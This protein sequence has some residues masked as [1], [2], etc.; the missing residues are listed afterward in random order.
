MSE[1]ITEEIKELVIA[2]LRSMPENLR[3][4]LGSIV[5]MDKSEIIDHVKKGDEIGGK[6]VE[7]QMRF[8]QSL[9][10]GILNG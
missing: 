9:R 2:R 5:G 1:E 4:S 6:I 7:I 3:V 10:R 8:V